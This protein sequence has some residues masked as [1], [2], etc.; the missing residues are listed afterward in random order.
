MPH[1]TVKL[2][3]GRSDEQKAAIADALA[4]ALIV[5]AGCSEASVSVSLEDVAPSDWVETVYKPEI[6][7]KP[8]QLF[9]KPGYNPLA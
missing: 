3:A 1:V 6:L 5:S 7:G 8:D 9:R 4:K 2:Y